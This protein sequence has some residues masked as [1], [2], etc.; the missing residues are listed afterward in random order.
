MP[1]KVIGGLI[2]AAAPITDPSA[3]IDK[4]RKAAIDAHLPFIEEAGRR[5][6]QIL[7]LQEVFNGP[8]NGYFMACSN[9]VGTEAPWN[10][11]RF[12]GSSYFVDSRGNLLAMGS[13]DKDELIV[14]E[15][16][17]RVMYEPSH[18]YRRQRGNVYRWGRL[19]RLLVINGLPALDLSP[20]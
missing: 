15:K 3:P 6:A 1:R 7:G 16:Q 5:G 8:A 2:Q 14:A 17:S 11:G 12:Y 4:V 18:F 10:I 13:E 9:R 19:N 20:L